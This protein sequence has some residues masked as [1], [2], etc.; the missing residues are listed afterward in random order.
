MSLQI[1]TDSQID[2]AKTNYDPDRKAF[3]IQTA[4]SNGTVGSLNAA[5]PRSAIDGQLVVLLDNNTVTVP[6]W[7]DTSYYHIYL[8]YSA[9]T[10]VIVIGGEN[11]VPEFTNP[12]YQQV[13][14]LLALTATLVLHR[15]RFHN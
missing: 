8:T 11:T 6:F 12:I 3:V 5:I 9:G 13:L 14:L 15:R 1:L 2:A 10:H 4:S 7:M